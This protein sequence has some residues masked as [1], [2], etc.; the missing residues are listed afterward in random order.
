MKIHGF[1]ESVSDSLEYNE[2]EARELESVSR[3]F[4]SNSFKFIQKFQIFNFEYQP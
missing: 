1:Y 3:I 4:A 2:L